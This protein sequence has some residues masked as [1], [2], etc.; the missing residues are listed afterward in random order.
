LKAPEQRDELALNSNFAVIHFFWDRILGT[1][2]RS[3]W[4]NSDDWNPSDRRSGRIFRHSKWK[5]LSD[6]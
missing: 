5:P 6:R 2:R 3:G 4:T 1:Y